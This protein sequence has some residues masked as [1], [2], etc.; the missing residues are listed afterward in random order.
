MAQMLNNNIPPGN[1]LAIAVNIGICIGILLTFPLQI[2]P[3]IE[4]L[5][6]YLFTEGNDYT[7][8]RYMRHDTTKP[9]K[10]H[11]HPAKT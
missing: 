6:K 7:L 5:E 11:V 4:I 9:R 10:W 3:V 8:H 2:F 1:P